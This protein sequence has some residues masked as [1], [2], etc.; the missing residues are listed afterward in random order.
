MICIR[1]ISMT[2]ILFT[3]SVD[4]H[5][6]CWTLT[7]FSYK[8]QFSI[9]NFDTFFMTITQKTHNVLMFSHGSWIEDGGEIE[10]L[11]YFLNERLTILSIIWGYW[12][13]VLVIRILEVIWWGEWSGWEIRI[14]CIGITW[15]ISLPIRICII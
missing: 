9:F 1:W 12:I 5:S 11:S 14:T 4:D 7:S 8:P 3:Y 6:F 10:K 2:Q 15:A 13:I